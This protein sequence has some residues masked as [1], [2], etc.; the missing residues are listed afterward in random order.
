MGYDSVNKS[1]VINDK[2]AVIVRKIF[3]YANQGLGFKAIT[4]RLSEEGYRSKIEKPPNVC[5]IKTILNN[6]LYIGKIRYNQLRNWSEKRRKGKNPDFLVVD[7]THEPIITS[8]I[9]ESV[10][11]KLG[12]R[13]NKPSRSHQP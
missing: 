9:W 10:H 7:G 12:Q 13:S 2:E 6:P 11:Q 8:D 1:L 3:N 4:R 5:G